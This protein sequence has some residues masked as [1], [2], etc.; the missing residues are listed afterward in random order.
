MEVNRAMHTKAIFVFLN[1]QS[2]HSVMPCFLDERS[3]NVKVWHL[4]SGTPT[5]CIG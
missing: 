2:K 3:P 5:A 1:C 4:Y